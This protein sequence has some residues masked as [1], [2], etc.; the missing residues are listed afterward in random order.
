MLDRLELLAVIGPAGSTGPLPA[1]SAAAFVDLPYSPALLLHSSFRAAILDDAEFAPAC[2]YGFE[3]YFEEMYQD[4]ETGTG[5]VFV[6]R[7]YSW[8]E[9]I[10][11]VM[12]NARSHEARFMPPSL[13]WDAG[14]VLGWLSAHALV[15]RPVALMALEVLHRLIASSAHVRPCGRRVG[16]DGW[17]LDM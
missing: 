14:F 7:S 3:A 16:G 17:P 15:D 6:A 2:G 8:A 13:A 10:D 12:E 4:N 1:V 5:S 11:F 9:V